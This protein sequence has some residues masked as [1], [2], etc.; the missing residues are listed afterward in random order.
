MLVYNISCLLID[1]YIKFSLLNFFFKYLRQ[2]I[3][4]KC[5]TE[6]KQPKRT[7]LLIESKP[8]EL[9]KPIP[10]FLLILKSCL[11]VTALLILLR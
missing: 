2:N 5:R 3:K 6:I 10:C 9:E 7:E 8:L 1:Y 11:I 4:N